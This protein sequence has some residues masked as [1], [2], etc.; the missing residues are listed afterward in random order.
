[1]QRAPV[2]GGAAKRGYLSA[3]EPRQRLHGAA[4]SFIRPP[5]PVAP[6]EHAVARQ[7]EKAPAVFFVERLDLPCGRGQRRGAAGRRRLLRFRKIGSEREQQPVPAVVVGQTELLE[8]PGVV[9]AVGLV[10][11]QREHGADRPPVRSG[12]VLQLQPEQPVRMHEA[13]QHRV[14]HGARQL[15]QRQQ[16]KRGRGRPAAPQ[17]GGEREQ[18]RQRAVQGDVQPPAALARREQR[19]MQRAVDGK[20]RRLYRL[21]APLLCQRAYTPAVIGAALLVHERVDAVVAEHGVHRVA[22]FQDIA[23]IE[24]AYGAQRGEGAR[25][26]RFV[27][28]AGQTPQQRRAQ[29]RAEQADLRFRKAP[30]PAH[31]GQIRAEPRLR[32][33]SGVQKAAGQRR[34]RA[35]GAGRTQPAGPPKGLARLDRGLAR[36]P[37]IVG[38]PCTCSF[39]AAEGGHGAQRPPYARALPPA[40][41]CAARRQL[42]RSP[43]AVSGEGVRSDFIHTCHFAPYAGEYSA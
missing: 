34:D 43:F 9:R 7:Q 31:A 10:R 39:L 30:G 4:L 18:Q 22:L 15:R 13:Q 33:L 27:Q 2:A 36:E 35:D 25:G 37:D 21:L 40:A 8:P 12:A 6:A 19:F 5:E 14:G 24:R 42:L 32:R 38:V 3:D 29:P 41:R 11:Q 17:S 1:M 28:P 23:Q 16:Q 20:G 26:L